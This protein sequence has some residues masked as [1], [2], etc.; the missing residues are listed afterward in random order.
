MLRLRQTR[1]RRI[2]RR[3]AYIKNKIISGYIYIYIYIYTCRKKG[4]ERDT[5]REIERDSESGIEN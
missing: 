4:R 5:E 3:A 2:S 1:L